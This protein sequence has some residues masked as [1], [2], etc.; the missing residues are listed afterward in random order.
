M[1]CIMI[2]HMQFGACVCASLGYCRPAALCGGVCAS[3]N[4]VVVPP[5]PSRKNGGG[6]RIE[7]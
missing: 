2:Q 5:P 1:F 3:G 4:I 7:V 6:V